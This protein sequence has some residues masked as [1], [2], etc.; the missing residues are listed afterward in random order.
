[1]TIAQWHDS[2]KNEFPRRNRFLVCTRE[3]KSKPIIHVAVAINESTFKIEGSTQQVPIQLM[4]QIYP[5]WADMPEPPN[6]EEMIVGKVK[7]QK[8]LTQE[9]VLYSLR[10]YGNTVINK[11]WLK[12]F[13]SIKE[14]ENTISLEYGKE[15]EILEDKNSKGCYTAWIK[16]GRKEQ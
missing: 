3:L 6:E 4:R 14:A 13:N 8:Q 15:V 5:Y 12:K 2:S 16:T 1:M 7:E 9:Y 11:K 10:K